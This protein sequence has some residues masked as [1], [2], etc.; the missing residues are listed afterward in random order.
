MVKK[1]FSS[2]KSAIWFQRMTEGAV[3]MQAVASAGLTFPCLFLPFEVDEE[4]SGALGAEGKQDTLQ[5]SRR[6][7][8]RQEQRPQA[9]RAQQPLQAQDL[10]ANL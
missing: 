2:T 6:H 9:R 4:E 7:R 8:Q 3:E 1:D 5:D 10:P